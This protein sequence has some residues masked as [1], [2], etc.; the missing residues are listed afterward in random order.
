[1][2][3]A[4][5][6]AVLAVL[7]PTTTGDQ[8]VTSSISVDPATHS[9]YLYA[10]YRHR[11]ITRPRPDRFGRW[12]CEPAPVRRNLTCYRDV[13]RGRVSANEVYIS[14]RR[15]SQVSITAGPAGGAS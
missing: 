10:T 6:V 12:T 15:R 8:P 7:I 2:T 5:L 3:A 9:A 4:H 14:F 11:T 1:M 13:L